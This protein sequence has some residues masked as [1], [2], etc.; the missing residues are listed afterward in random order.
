[1]NV[2]EE[3]AWSLLVE[4][5]ARE[6]TIGGKQAR[7]RCGCPVYVVTDFYTVGQTGRDRHEPERKALLDKIRARKAAEP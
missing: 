3:R 6:T 1:M 4:L 7:A 5:G 2:H